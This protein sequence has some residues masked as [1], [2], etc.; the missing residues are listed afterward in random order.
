M[1]DIDC[2]FCSSC[3]SYYDSASPECPSCA[4]GRYTAT[5]LDSEHRLKMQVVDLSVK[6]AELTE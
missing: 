6:V 2:S 4:N 1:T 3:D 5:L